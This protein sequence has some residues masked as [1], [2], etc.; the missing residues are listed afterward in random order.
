MTK[1]VATILYL[2]S[3]MR[4]LVEN[5]SETSPYV[6]LDLASMITLVS[7]SVDPLSTCSSI[8]PYDDAHM[9]LYSHDDESGSFV[10]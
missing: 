3:F 7:T 6:S 5:P 9:N 10:V 4:P 8:N 2:S 1:P